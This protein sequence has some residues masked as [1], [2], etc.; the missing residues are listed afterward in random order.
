MQKVSIRQNI[1][2]LTPIICIYQYGNRLRYE[3]RHALTVKSSLKH[4]D[5][6]N[7]LGRAYVPTPPYN[8]SRFNDS[9]L[10]LLR[11]DAL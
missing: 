6:T 10:L 2:N 3:R 7:I 9:S 8:C 1:L 4:W 11:Q 5:L